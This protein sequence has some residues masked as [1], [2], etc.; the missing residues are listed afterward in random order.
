MD[1]TTIP[2]LV[3]LA[4]AGVT[5]LAEFWH[6]RRSR[7]L[8]RL[9]FGPAQA[10]RPWTRIAPPL[11]LAACTLLAWGLTLLALA[12]PELLGSAAGEELQQET[13]PADMQRVLLVLD[14]S[15]SMN[16][17]DAGPEQTMRRRDRV[18]QVVDGV[19]SRIALSRT[20]FS[21]VVFFTSARPVVV[22]ATDTQ[23]VRNI[24][25][26]LPLVWSFEPGR[27]RLVE[28][29]IAAGE[30]A[31]DW[32]PDS[33]TMFLCTDGDTVDFSQVPELP[34]SIRDVQILAVG[35]P[36]RGTR[37]GAHESRQQAAI[38]KRLAVELRGDYYN[39]NRRHLPSE[40]LADLARVPP[41]PPDEGLQFKD[42]ARIA[43]G[44]GAL[45]LVLLPV[46]LQYFGSS[47]KPQRELPGSVKGSTVKAAARPELVAAE[48]RR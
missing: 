16:A 34:R 26:N 33:T 44:L 13:D 20:K 28:G 32:P 48:D 3:A 31:E 29:L 2:I 14:V 17:E 24:L 27:T 4:V 15:P 43:V 7:E 11:R 12:E 9:T 21:I 8:S 30:L 18:M 19:L 6:A 40:A 22:D 35:D 36:L 39:V 47:W 10:P 25:D 5:G 1:E 23:V 42:V 46:A 38:L 41:P 37:V 45:I